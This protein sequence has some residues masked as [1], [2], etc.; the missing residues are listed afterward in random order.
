MIYQ[1]SGYHDIDLTDKLPTI[2]NSEIDVDWISGAVLL[3]KTDKLPSK[4]LNS[5]FFFGCEDV[6]LC[7]EMKNKGYKMVTNLNAI[8]W[9]KAG[10]SKSKV[11]FR[12]FQR[13]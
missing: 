3:I 6:D 10:A 5:E 1:I 13:K 7:I 11:K 9:H 4:L 8:V 12:G 2:K